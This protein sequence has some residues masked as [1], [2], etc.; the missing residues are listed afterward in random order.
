MQES[1]KVSSTSFDY[2]LLVVLY[3]LFVRCRFSRFLFYCLLGIV[4]T[5]PGPCVVKTMSVSRQLALGVL[6]TLLALVSSYQPAAAP[7]TTTRG[8]V[9]SNRNVSLLSSAT[10]SISATAAATALSLLLWTTPAPAGASP[11]AAQISLNQIPPTSITVKIDDLPFVGKILSG[12][13]TKVPDGSFTGN[14]SIV[15]TSPSDKV[16]AIRQIAT[17]GHLEFDVQGKINTHLDVDIAAD[18]PGVARVRVAS[19]LIPPLPFKNLASSQ[20]SPTGGRESA[21]NIVTNMGNGYVTS[22][23]IVL[24]CHTV[25]TRLK[26]VHDMEMLLTGITHTGSHC[27]VLPIGN[28]TTGKAITTTSRPV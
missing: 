16:K 26:S 18:E 13:Y 27:L 8:F 6:I 28:A 3:W 7:K 20:S 15:I 2:R 10:P 21:W 14:P 12:T 5:V 22:Q 19:E 24:A 23:G 9:P 1:Q 17:G 25:Q 4:K 11:T